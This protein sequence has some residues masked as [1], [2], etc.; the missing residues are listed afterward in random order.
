LTR[1]KQYFEKIKIAEEGPTKPRENLTLN[2]EAAG[3]VIKH[4]LV[5]PDD[6]H[7]SVYVGLTGHRLAMINMISNELKEKRRRDLLRSANF[8]NWRQSKRRG[9]RL[10]L[11]KRNPATHPRKPATALKTAR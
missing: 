8:T 3:R 7:I 10:R 5:R 2:K 6:S 1:V 11:R 4:A 9:L